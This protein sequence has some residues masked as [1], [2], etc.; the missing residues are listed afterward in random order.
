[1]SDLP[2]QQLKEAEHSRCSP[3]LVSFRA[4]GVFLCSSHDVILSI[5]PRSV[6]FRPVFPGHESSP[7]PFMAGALVVLTAHVDFATTERRPLL[8]ARSA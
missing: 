3:S 5:R 2:Q 8:W 6:E 4:V 1:M 7:M